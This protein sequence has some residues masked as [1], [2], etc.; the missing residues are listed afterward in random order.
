[1]EMIQNSDLELSSQV[2]ES[3]CDVGEYLVMTMKAAV[4]VVLLYL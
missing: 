3:G 2:A 4:N 1:M